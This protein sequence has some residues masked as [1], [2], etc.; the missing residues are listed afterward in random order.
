MGKAIEQEALLRG[1]RIV[2]AMD[3]INKDLTADSLK[4][5]D[6]AIEFTQP[7]AA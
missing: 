2:L 1:H 3:L 5:A 6:I 4:A 7:E